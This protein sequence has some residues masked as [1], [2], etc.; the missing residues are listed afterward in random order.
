MAGLAQEIA[1]SPVVLHDR[2]VQ[3][4]LGQKHRN[5]NNSETVKDIDW[6][7]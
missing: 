5:V 7:F 2:S 1:T 4:N 3:L 6:K